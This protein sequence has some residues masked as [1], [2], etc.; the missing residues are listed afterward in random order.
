MKSRGRNRSVT[1]GETSL[2]FGS[3]Q[4]VANVMLDGNIISRRTSSSISSVSFVDAWQLE[5]GYFRARI[6]SMPAQLS[7]MRELF[8][9]DLKC[10]DDAFR[11]PV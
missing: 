8:G 10:I 11:S 6:D 2:C 1:Q 4:L 5:N 9:A 3:R 7:N